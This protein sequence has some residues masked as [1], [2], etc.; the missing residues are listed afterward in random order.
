M[1]NTYIGLLILT[2]ISTHIISCAGGSS[3]D[4]KSHLSVP[5]LQRELP[6][7]ANLP[8]D[9][10]G[11]YAQYTGM[12]P[13]IPGILEGAV[14]QGMAYW[15]E[16]DTM[17]ISNYMYNDRPGVLTLV[18]MEEQ[19]QI[20]TVWLQNHDGLPHKDHLGGLAVLGNTLWIASGRY[21]YHLPLQ[22]ISRA[23]DNAILTLPPPMY[24]EVTA[25]FASNFGEYLLIGE[26]RNSRRQYQT[27]ASHSYRTAGGGYN[28]A[29]M[30][31]F[32]TEP[33]SGTLINSLSESGEV[34]PEFFLSI[35]DEVQGAAFVEDRIIL[36]QSYGRR[37]TSRLSVYRS[38]LSGEADA[39]FTLKDG[40]EV[41]VWF[42]DYSNLQ[43]VSTLPPMS[44]GI[45]DYY[46]S[47]A[48]LY[49][50]GANKYRRSAYL[51]QDRIHLL[52]LEF[53]DILN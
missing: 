42:L 10:F 44:E 25:S 36:S 29:L 6:G 43:K 19:E 21:F 4:A 17:I 45:V 46:G 9:D 27:P 38:P 35:P 41:P 30:A 16:E 39:T 15:D 12:G 26:F 37:R 14:P 34:Q 47:L 53:L 22:E 31:A 51:P 11:T 18:S 7:G 23:D 24:S 49:E 20:K 28:Y 2:F 48:V 32:E 8:Q 13:L 3:E 52:D 40:S 1:K 50:S 5:L 33:Y